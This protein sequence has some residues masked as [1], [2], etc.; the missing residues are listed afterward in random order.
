MDDT[1]TSPA[2]A[3]TAPDGAF[4]ALV[5]E[6][7]AMLPALAPE[8][9]NHNA[10]D[11]GITLIEL[12]AYFTDAL[13]YRLDRIDHATRFEF[14]RLLRGGDLGALAGDETAGAAALRRAVKAAL[15]E[16]AQC[17]CAVTPGD[18]V[19]FAEAALRALPW[20]DRT[21]VRCLADTNLAGAAAQGFVPGRDRGHVSVVVLPPVE[22]PAA[23]GDVLR[24]AVDEA[25]AARRL[26]GC[27]LHV[28]APLRLHVGVRLAATPVTG[29]D[30][31]LLAERLSRALADWRPDDGPDD[32]PVSLALSEIAD[33][34]AEVEGVEGVDGVML[35]Q[36][37]AHAAQLQDAGS[38]VGLQ[39]GR[40]STIGRDSRLGAA[41]PL[42]S[43][44]L[45]RSVDGRLAAVRLQPWEQAHV[46]L[47][48][49]DVHWTDEPGA[50]PGA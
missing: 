11:P 21:R 25:L 15:D 31:R 1:S 19:D 34:A 46:V 24:A 36:A 4:Q 39:V 5:A 40:R 3:T 35:L 37:S 9:T 42:S 26:L 7:L 2:L 49:A 18:H 28:S 10:S 44:R 8:W 50:G 30:R 16:T 47:R 29:A 48:P 41:A 38:A 45:V 32:G 23:A 12:L 20:G 13:Q 17:D 43:A 14:L 6:G 22:C 33:R 27:R